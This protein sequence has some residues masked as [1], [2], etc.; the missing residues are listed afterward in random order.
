MRILYLDW[1][2]V[3]AV[4]AIIAIFAYACGA[5]WI[6]AGSLGLIVYGA[7]TSPKTWTAVVVTVADLNTHIR[8]NL[9]AFLGPQTIY[10]DGMALQ[11]DL[12]T[13]CDAPTTVTTT[14]GRPMVMGCGFSG[15]A[16]QYAHFKL[17]F[18][19]QW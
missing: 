1:W 11:P 17:A 15:T 6:P 19:K 10:V 14:A 16:D 2:R 4:A 7:W 18:P 8:D 13:P 3:A 12:T 9:N 5:G